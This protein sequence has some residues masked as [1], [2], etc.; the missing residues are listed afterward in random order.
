MDSQRCGA[1]T[2]AVS[3]TGAEDRAKLFRVNVELVLNAV[4]L[5]S[6]LFC[7]RIVSRGVKR[8]HG[9]LTR[10]P[11]FDPPA[12]V[13]SPFIDN[14]KTM[15]RWTDIR[16]TAASHTTHAGML[17]CRVC[18]VPLQIISDQR[19]IEFDFRRRGGFSDFV[20][21]LRL[22]TKQ[23]GSLFRENPNL[24]N[25]RTDLK[26]HCVC[27][28]RG[29]RCESDRRAETIF[30]CFFAGERNDCCVIP[31]LL[32]K[33]VLIIPSEHLVENRQARRIAR[34]RADDDLLL[35][36]LLGIGD[37]KLLSVVPIRAKSFASGKNEFLD[38]V[39][40]HHRRIENHCLGRIDSLEKVATIGADWSNNGLPCRQEPS[41]QQI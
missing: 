31:A 17:K 35:G 14:I 22:S 5:S 39:R 8:E 36:D 3:A 38:G 32:V 20:R 24:K 33:A 12:F 26:Q 40:R 25:I 13:R 34:T 37:D 9:K 29:V 1:D 19:R 7:P 30:V 16:A 21:L 41:H 4:A 15:A 28:G 18:K 2:C 6:R 23:C 10:I 11:I 27:A